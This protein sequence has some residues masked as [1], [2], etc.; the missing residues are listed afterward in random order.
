VKNEF[1]TTVK[2]CL[3]AISFCFVSFRFVLV[4][5]ILLSAGAGLAKMSNARYVPKAVQLED[6]GGQFDFA[7][8]SARTVHIHVCP[9]YV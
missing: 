5:F 3:T 4:C 6:N 9:E 7:S 1:A 2:V 8:S